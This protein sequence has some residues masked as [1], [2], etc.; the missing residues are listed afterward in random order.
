[1]AENKAQHPP[2]LI[3][4]SEMKA[5]PAG[6]ASAFSG[7]IGLLHG[8]KVKV[9]VVVGEVQTT[10]GE[11]MNLK[12]SAVLKIDRPVDSAIDVIVEGNVV[13]RGE[14]VAVGDNFGIR[15]TEIAAPA[16]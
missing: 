13:A 8:V 14:L 7:N 4:L 9:E 1:M 10:L 11:L 16:K 15:I 2:Q 12:E 6:G 3:E 5:Q